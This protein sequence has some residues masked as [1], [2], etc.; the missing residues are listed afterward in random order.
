VFDA[1]EL[2]ARTRSW[3][4]DH[5]YLLPRERDI[6][7]LAV[8]ARRHREQALSKHIAAGAGDE[9]HGWP[10]QLLAP[11]EPGG[12]T[13][14]EWLRATPPGK[15]ARS[16]E[17]QLDK[18][19]FLKALGADRLVFPDLPLVGQ[20]E[21]NGTIDVVRGR[22]L[23]AEQQCTFCHRGG[24]WTKTVLDFTP[25]PTLT[26]IF[27]ERDVGAPLNLLLPGCATDPDLT[28]VNPNACRPVPRPL[29]RGCRLVQSRRRRRRQRAWQQYRRRREVRPR[30]GMPPCA[31]ASPAVPHSGRTAGC[32]HS[33][34]ARARNRRNRSLLI[35]TSCI[36]IM[37]ALHT[38]AAKG[39]PPD[40]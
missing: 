36:M 23:F 5:H 12:L 15:A 17:E 6:R 30:S 27:C 3:L 29:P 18:I 1:A 14:L 40:F 39:L 32:E 7:R 4:V 35:R 26:D 34:L 21:L 33:F 28:V 9:R 22:E 31:S 10:A 24:L 16:L 19:H 2:I 25:P 20:K 11:A 13:H 8:A 37:T 38:R